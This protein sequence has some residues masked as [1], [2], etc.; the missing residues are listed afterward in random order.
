MDNTRLTKKTF[1]SVLQT[2]EENNISRHKRSF[3]A[4]LRLGILPLEIEIRRFGNIHV[5]NRLYMLR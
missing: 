1:N 4:Q 3:L 5:E 2:E